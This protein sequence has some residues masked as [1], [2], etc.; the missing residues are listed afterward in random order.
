M[1][2]MEKQAE[3]RVPCGHD[4][5]CVRLAASGVTVAYCGRCER[6]F[7]LGPVDARSAVAINQYWLPERTV[8][9]F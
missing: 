8:A 5:D 3:P 2:T 4:A 1:K 6:G 9:S 7:D